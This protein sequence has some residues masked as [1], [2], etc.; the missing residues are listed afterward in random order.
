MSVIPEYAN[1]DVALVPQTPAYVIHLGAL[2][3][4]AR[5]LAEVQSQADCRILLAL[6][7][8]ATHATFPTIARYLSG[9][10]ASGLHEALLGRDTFDGDVHVYSPAYKP[11]ELDALLTFAHTLVFN[12]PSH[13]RRYRKA[14]ATN[15]RYIH[16]GLRINH[17]H[18][19]VDVD[20]YN[21]CIPG[22]RLGYPAEQLQPSDL[23]GLD[24]LHFHTM[25]EQGADVLERSLAAFARTCEPYFAK[26]KWLNFGGG[27]HITQPDYD[28]EH[29]IAL[30]Q[31]WRERYGL[32][33]YLE[34]GEAIAV[35]TGVLVAEVLDTFDS[36]GITVAIVDV[37]ATAHMP[38][39]LEMPYRPEIIGAEMPG[40]LAHTY[41]LGGPTCLAG[42]I[43]GDY[44]FAEP[45]HVGKRLVFLD[46]SHYT[47]VKT[48][49]FN[50]VP[51]PDICAYH[52][53]TNH[54]EVLRRFTYADFRSRLG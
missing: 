30:L 8:F 44:S 36:K 4:N 27:H 51:H 47:M 13:W 43:I 6:K 22:S 31:A 21:P 16:R 39:T 18:S 53:E 29:L 41:R 25:C 33:L 45:L 34:P 17:G 37:S 20:L 32:E 26:L 49:T 23:D 38:D 19:E 1:W 24:G 50:G 12:T 15:P 9:V 28:R 5:I 42:D 10:T 48:T 54:V 40:T 35:N 11:E 2:E 3:A 14:V 52:P 7:A 46:M